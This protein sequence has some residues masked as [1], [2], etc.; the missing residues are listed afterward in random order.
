M[1]CAGQNA[2]RL[3]KRKTADPVFTHKALG[4][5]RDGCAALR[6]F[7]DHLTHRLEELIRVLC[8]NGILGQITD[9]GTDIRYPASISDSC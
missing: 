3:P 9:K 6:A 1:L 7:A 8:T 2:A 4:P 5:V